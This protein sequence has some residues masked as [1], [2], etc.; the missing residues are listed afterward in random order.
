MG[1][2]IIVDRE[3]E[4]EVYLHEVL[5][6]VL[7]GINNRFDARTKLAVPTGW[8]SE[9]VNGVIILAMLN[10]GWINA[11]GEKVVEGWNHRDGAEKRLRLVCT[12]LLGDLSFDARP[13]SSVD[14]AREIRNAFAHAKPFVER[15]TDLGL[16]I[17]ESDTTAVF[18]ALK[19]PV[20]EDITIESY[21]RLRED[22]EQFRR[23]LLERS[24]LRHWDVKTK[25]HETSTF[26]GEA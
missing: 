9:A 25:S 15:R 20:E 19:H 4:R 24:G 5:E 16:V 2:R 21:C 6:G 14:M 8:K 17:D 13:L 26:R 18:E 12:R 10:E 22:S 1:R 3:L 7:H 23:L 11:I